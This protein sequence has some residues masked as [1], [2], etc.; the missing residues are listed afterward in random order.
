M[1]TRLQ[2]EHPVT[3][4]IT[5]ID[6]VQW[7]LAVAAGEPLP[8]TQDEITATGHAIEVRV[9]A[10]DPY[11]GFLPQAGHV[12]AVAW[13]EGARVETDL[14]A[15]CRGVDG[16]RPDARQDRRARAP[17]ARTPG[18]AMVEALDDTGDL[19]RH[20]Q[21]RLRAAAR[22]ERRSSPRATSTRPGSTATPSA[23]LLDGARRARGGRARRRPRLWATLRRRAARR[24]RS[25]A[26]TAGGRAASRRRCTVV[27]TTRPGTRWTSRLASRRAGRRRRRSRSST[28]TASRSPGR[29]QTWAFER[30]DPMR[31]GHRRGAATDADVG[32]ADAR[33]GAAGRRRRGRRGRGRSAARRRRGDEDGAAADRPVR[34]HRHRTSARPRGDQVPIKHLL[35]TVE[36]GMTR[37]MVVRDDAL[38]AAVDDL[39][40]RSARRP[41]ERVGDRAGRRSR[42][43]SSSACVGGGPADRRGDQLRPPE[44]GAAAG[45]RRR[46]RRAPAARRP[47]AAAGAGAERAR[48]RP[49]AR[50]RRRATSRSSPAPPRRSRARTSTRRSTTSSRCSSPSSSRAREAGLDVRAYV[51]MCFGDPWEGAVAIDQ[52]VAVG[53]PAARPRARRSCR[54]ATRSASAPPAHVA[55]LVRRVRRGRDRRGL[56]GDALPRHLRP[57]A[58]QR[59]RGAAGRRHDVRRVRRRPRRLPVRRERD[60]QPRDR[61][62]RLDARRPRH[63]ARRRPGGAR[64]DERLDGRGARQGAGQRRRPRPAPDP[65][66]ASGAFPYPSGAFWSDTPSQNGRTHHSRGWSRGCGRGSRASRG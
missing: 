16:V 65:A 57:G 15:R 14:E 23:E 30:P 50:G 51:S 53:T 10:E 24:R 32:L 39:R 31:G 45:R 63:R 8:L 36:P 41:A 1:N 59:A 5:G 61:G 48:A 7:Q 54:S 60:R 35:F 42:S 21:R 43:S 13:P 56:A 40:G 34:R 58:R 33:H 20:D 38:P 18:R 11:A 47:D 37:P 52:V 26:S 12:D 46:A 9:Y 4:E 2:V 6:L 19:R 64:R 17:T 3:E 25:A 66:P 49:G 22:R 29:A 44:V 28:A 55:A 27:L 62:P